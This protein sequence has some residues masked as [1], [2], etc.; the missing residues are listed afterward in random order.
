MMRKYLAIFVLHAKTFKIVVYTFIRFST[1]WVTREKIFFI[2]T[3]SFHGN[4]VQGIFDIFS[5]RFVARNRLKNI[6]SVVQNR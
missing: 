5:S 3:N 1:L 6:Y 2:F 4:D